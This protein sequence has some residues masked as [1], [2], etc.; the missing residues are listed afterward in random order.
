[1][2][3]NDDFETDDREDASGIRHVVLLGDGLGDLARM[4]QSGA[5]EGRLLPARSEPWKL[6]LLSASDIARTSLRPDIPKDATHV[7]ISIEGN[8]AIEASGVLG[9]QPASYEEGL[10]RLSFAADQFEDQVEALI[11]AGQA[12]RLPTVICT[13]WPPRYPEPVRQ[14]AAV[15]A[16]TIFNW[17]IFCCALAA[18]ISIVD[19]HNA[20]SDQSDYADDTLLSMSGLRKA[21]NVVSRALREVTS[22]GAGTEVFW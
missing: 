9:G 5:L 15:A 17:R 21:A 7:V 11:R 22:R 4:Q 20:C 14:R 10:A 13:M 18:G 1:M 2:I 16:L 12:T 3:P 8:R 19:L 6:T